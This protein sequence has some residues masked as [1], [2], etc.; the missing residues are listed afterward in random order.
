VLVAACV[1]FGLVALLPPAIARLRYLQARV[2]C[3]QNLHRFH[4]ALMAYGDQHHSDLPRV[5]ETERRNVGGIFMPVLYD[6]GLLAPDISTE[7]PADGK[8]PAAVPALKD[9]DAMPREAFQEWA[10][11]LTGGYSYALGYR[12][13]T[14]RLFGYRRDDD[15]HLPIM[16][17]RPL[18]P[19]EKGAGYD[20]GNSPNHDGGQNVLYLGGAVTFVKER[21]VGVGGD[22]IFLNQNRQVAA[23]LNRLD[24]VLGVGADRP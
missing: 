21:T 12:D 10:S 24:S 2:A 5:E 14:G 23:G 16:S 20:R 22:D 4:Q 3:Q 19:G 17:D 18:L 9:L 8:E 13:A 6:A 7:C 15:G 1:L 11:R